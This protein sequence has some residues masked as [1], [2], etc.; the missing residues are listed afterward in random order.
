MTSIARRVRFTSVVVALAATA[1]AIHSSGRADNQVQNQEAVAKAPAGA[2]KGGGDGDAKAK[3]FPDLKDVIKDMQPTEGLF[4]LY[5][6]DPSDKERD[7]EKLLCKIPKKLLNE[8]LLFATS[9]SRGGQF[10]GWMWR[11]HLIRW[12]VI[13]K[14][15]KMVT[16]DTRYVHK[17]GKPVTDVVKRTYTETFL[18]SLP[19]VT[20]TPGGDP[21]F[22]MG[23]L[24]KSNLADVSFMGPRGARIRPELSKWTKIKVFPDNVLI[25]VDLAMEGKGGG[26]SVGVSYAFRR[27]PKLDSYTPRM[28]DDRIG[29]FLTAKM[30]WSKEPGARD[31]FV[32]YINRWRLEKRDPSLELSPPKKPITFIIEKT[33]PIQWRR[34]VRQGIEDWNKAFEK[35]GFVD[36]IVVQQQTAD[37]EFADYDPE[38]ARYNF[39]R[40]IVSGRAFAMGPSRVDPRTGQILDADI[41]MDDSF[42]RAWMQDFDV[43]APTSLAEL[44][45]P[46]FKAW[47]EQNR[48]LLPA[49][50]RYQPAEIEAFAGFG[51]PVRNAQ[52]LQEI[53]EAK[54][55]ANG[56]HVCSYAFGL[57]QQL[58]FVGHAL[59]ATGSGKKLPERFIGEAIREAVVHEVGH[60]LGLRHN[61]KASSWLTLEEV[62]QRRDSGDEPLSASVMDYNPLLFFAGDEPE[63]VGHF[64][65]PTIG[66]WDYWVIEYGY[67]VPDKG[68]SEKEMLQEIAAR[69]TEKGLDY[70]TDEDTL[71]VTSPDPLSNRYDFSSDLV[72]WARSR[73]KLTEQLTKDIGQWAIRAGEP[74]YHIREAFEQ[75]WFERARNF[76]YVARLVGGQ[77]FHR[78]HKGDPDARPPFVLV[79]AETQRQALNL[80]KETLFSDEF[81]QLDPELFNELA[82]PRWSHWGSRMPARLDYPIHDRINMLQLHALFDLLTPPVIQRVYD[83]ELKSTDP[84]RFT[85]AELLRTL[86]DHIWG[87]AYKAGD[88]PYS[89]SK[90]FI[91][92][93]TR[94]LQQA[95]LNLML[96][97]A[98]QPP[99]RNVSSDLYVMIRYSLRELGDKIG[100]TLAKSGAKLDFASRAHLVECRSRTDRVLE[101]EFSAR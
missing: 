46:G 77:Y 88:G 66:P 64:A 94:N 35:I 91:S 76:E 68:D 16:P 63:T 1:F 52:A 56:R 31:T 71:W 15:L 101:A 90:P 28:A 82:P 60:T 98:Q 22:D 4:T 43:F 85:A 51:D 23:K 62:K 95:Y 79:D 38:D 34:W 99:G 44:K 26:R 53:A 17:K 49:F 5:R 37:N 54:L 84:D 59:V 61:F 78:D 50:L 72:S 55:R 45:G 100:V 10:T 58:A 87:S 73:I 9:I 6:Y 57:Q 7:S 29:Y 39:F 97:N 93:I 65:T 40:W 25:D 92:S 21:V 32:R 11:D 48:D 41:I 70:A 24:L 18:V 8:D 67:R 47:M 75:L 27:L 33:V 96:V 86:R 36:A 74:R 42:V 30:D 81:F 14:Y 12:E 69:C 20:M 2:P 3:R 89:D 19:I 80:L 83:A 13:G